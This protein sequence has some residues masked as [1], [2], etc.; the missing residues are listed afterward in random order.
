MAAKLRHQ[1]ETGRLQPGEALPSETRLAQRHGVSRSTAR[2]AL[3][4]LETAGLVS[5]LH[6]KGRYVRQDV[7]R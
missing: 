3:I 1:I 5:C 2:E 4:T 6:G 7:P